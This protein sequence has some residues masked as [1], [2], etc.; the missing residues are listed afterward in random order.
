[1]RLLARERRHGNPIINT[2]R[3]RS[4][5]LPGPVRPWKMRCVSVFLYRTNVNKDESPMVRK[6]RICIAI[7]STLL[8]APFAYAAAPAVEMNEAFVSEAPMAKA[9]GAAAF[10]TREATAPTLVALGAPALADT[11][12]LKS[13]RIDQVKRG[14]PF[15][16]GFARNVPNGRISL[17][18]L[19]W[20][21]QGDGSI[22]ARFG[23]SSETAVAMRAGLT[24]KSNGRGNPAGV[25][26]RFGGNDGRVFEQNGRE[27][28]GRQAGWSP[29]LMGD[30]ATVE[31]VL[32]KGQRPQNFSLAVAQISHLDTSPI[33]S[34]S[35]LA[36]LGTKIGESD[37]CEKDIVCRASPTGGFL[38][39]EK[40]VARMVFTKS[41]SSYLCTG[42]LLNNSH[43]PKKRL[44][45]SAAHCINTQTVA[46]TLQTYWFYKATTCGGTTQ[47]AGAV[48]LTGGA[49]LRHSNTTRDTLL[50]ELKTAPPAGAV[51]ASWTSA[52]I[53]ATGTSI[54]GIHHPAG[55]AKMY[56]LGSVTG[57]ST[58]IDGKSPLYRVVWNTGVTEGGSS[59]SALF[60][61][62]SS[63]THQLRGGLYGGL[64]YCTAPTQPDYYSRFSDVYSSISTYFA[65]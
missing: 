34:E 36:K 38:N 20:E 13:R 14:Q 31:I 18:R 27:F 22:A 32:A 58:S 35:A 57:L 33:A 47:A 48:T 51:Y 3:E 29:V 50:L 11:R 19:G 21:R 52:S 9:M 59:G 25:T 12:A 6:T 8:A 42:T 23:I 16:V 7:V 26:L 49:Y 28:V 62:N 46:N 56:S 44:F 37:S 54:V 1:M 64:S 39:A 30:N 65:P 43:S 53:G 60:T 5:A 61:V 45:W 24:L 17:S 63:G 41:G 10:A 40:A 15:E 55:D 2:L 4:Q